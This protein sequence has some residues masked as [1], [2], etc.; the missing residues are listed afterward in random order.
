MGAIYTLATISH[1]ILDAL[2]SKYNGGVELFWPLY[3]ERIRFGIVN[4]PLLAQVSQ[5]WSDAFYDFIVTCMIEFAFF[6]PIFI[7]VLFLRRAIKLQVR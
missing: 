3:K 2:T 5:S 7:A 6:A 4:Y 1:P